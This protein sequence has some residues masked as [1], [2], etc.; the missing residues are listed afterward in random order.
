MFAEAL[1]LIALDFTG[2]ISI[3]LGVAQVIGLSLF[4]TGCVLHAWS[5]AVRGR[6]A[7]TWAM[8][9]DQKLI[10]VAPYSIVCHPSYLAYMLMIIGVTLIWQLLFT[11]LPWIA[12]PGYYMVSKKEETLL[13]TIL[14]ASTDVIWIR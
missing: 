1:A 6:Y 10:T 9:T 2:N 13:L 5:V 8:S 3:G 4:F 14:E 11:L 7:V 12:I